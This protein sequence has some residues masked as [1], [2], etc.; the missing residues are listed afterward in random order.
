MGITAANSLQAIE[1]PIVK[2]ATY[3]GVAIFWS[4]IDTA[5][6][7]NV[8]RDG[9]YVDTVGDVPEYVP[10]SSGQYQIAAFDGKGNYSPLN[11]INEFGTFNSFITTVNTPNAT[12]GPVQNVTGIVYSNNAGELYWDRETSR[13]LSY[14]VTLNGV[15]LGSTT[16]NSF[17]I[18][19]LLHGTENR[20]TLTASSGSRFE[21]DPTTIIFDTRSN[22]Y[23]TAAN[24]TTSTLATG[25]GEIS[26]PQNARIESYAATIAEL[27]W[28]RASASEN[29]VTTEIFRD[30]VLIGTSP[31]NSFYDDTRSPRTNYTYDI[32]AINAD[33]QRSAPAVVNPN[34]FDGEDEEVV[35][36]M[37]AEFPCK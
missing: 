22:Y 32:I 10:N 12:V 37:L 16:G 7:Y 29:V 5:I 2:N 20:I 33:G 28:D 19:S 27:F 21:S 30:N 11:Q 35:L 6:G 26:A 34:G 23:P 17:W 14:S 9:F 4:A 8:Y 36:S 15:E 13:T 18:D 24:L 25:D 31:G 1:L 3:N